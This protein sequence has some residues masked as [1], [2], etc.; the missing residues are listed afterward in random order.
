V[1]HIFTQA[2]DEFSL[3]SRIRRRCRSVRHSTRRMA[4][5]TANIIALTVALLSS[6]SR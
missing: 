6:I 2:L 5:W 4:C 1:G 3:L